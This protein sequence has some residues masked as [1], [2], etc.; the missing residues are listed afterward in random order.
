VTAP[1]HPV[2]RAELL[3]EVVSRSAALPRER[4]A[5]S[6]LA[7]LAAQPHESVLEIGF[8]KGRLLAELAARLAHGRVTGIDPSELM[9]RHARIRCRRWIERGRLR[10]V[11]GSSADLS[12]FAN[13]SFDAALAVHVVSFWEDPARDLRE[14]HRVLRPGGRLVLGFL[15]DALDVAGL[16]AALRASGF[17]RTG[18][19]EEEGLVW[20]RG[21]R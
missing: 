19:V 15:P 14:I 21:L 9:E 10:L 16:D 11:R 12:A 17:A 18:H 2:V 13:A 8:G 20:T 7:Q 4:V 6:A 1:V 3:Y 5:R